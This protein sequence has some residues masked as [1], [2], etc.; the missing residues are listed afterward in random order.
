MTYLEI[1]N[2]KSI[3]DDAPNK[4]YRNGPELEIGL[5]LERFDWASSSLN[6]GTATYFISYFID[7]VY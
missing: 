6:L 3:F 5:L 4:V 2:N 1:F 7:I